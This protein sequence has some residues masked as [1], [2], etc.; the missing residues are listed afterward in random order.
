MAV[1]TNRIPDLDVNLNHI[2][3]SQLL[4]PG[5]N[6]LSPIQHSEIYATLLDTS[7]NYTFITNLDERESGLFGITKRIKTL[8]NQIYFFISDNV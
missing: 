7:N 3:T 2:W 6:C 1:M 4:S 5:T 8:Y